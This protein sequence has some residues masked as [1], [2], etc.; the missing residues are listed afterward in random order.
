[1]GPKEQVKRSAEEKWEILQDGLKS[2]N[3]G[4]WPGTTDLELVP[5]V[6]F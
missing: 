5:Q 3:I 6:R 4:G 2:G 1:M